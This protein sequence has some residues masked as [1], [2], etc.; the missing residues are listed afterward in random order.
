[1]SKQLL[2]ENISK[3]D[4]VENMKKLYK[5]MKK[6]LP[7]ID[8]DPKVFFKEDKRNADDILGK[9][10][11]Y[12]PNSSEIHIFITDRHAKDILR[13]FAHE[14]IHHEQ[15]C[16]GI[17]DNLD[18][19]K[20]VQADYASKDKGLREAER[21]AF[22]RGNMLFRDWTDRLKAKRDRE[23]RIMNEKKDK[24]NKKPKSKKPKSETEKAAEAG[25]EAARNYHKHSTGKDLKNMKDQRDETQQR[26]KEDTNNTPYPEL[27]EKK[28]RVLPDAFS[29]REDIIYQELIKRFTTEEK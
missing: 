1:M 8:H 17:T 24:K 4:L 26:I 19:S 7:K 15:K 9:T 10:G 28:E 13:S 2:F 14:L 23:T 27:F 18:L 3:E 20:T 22:R 16:S 5:Y 6:R 11:Y 29:K 21:D 25:K 12:D